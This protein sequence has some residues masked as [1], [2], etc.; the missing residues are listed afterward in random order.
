MKK[1]FKF[2][3]VFAIL[4]L[5]SIFILYKTKVIS[6][7]P[8]AEIN[9]NAPEGDNALLKVVYNDKE[10]TADENEPY[11]LK[12]KEQEIL[13]TITP[14]KGSVITLTLNNSGDTPIQYNSFL[15]DGKK[16]FAAPAKVDA[17]TPYDYTF[18]TRGNKEYQIEIQWEVAK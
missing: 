14:Q 12:T 4:V 3:I 9:I 16:A 15:I 11:S 1:V 10:L 17:D 5:L 8:A 13:F 6:T 7:S 18:I 2:I